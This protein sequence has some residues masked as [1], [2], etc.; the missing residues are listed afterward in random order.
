MQFLSIAK[1]SAGEVRAQLYVAADQ[2][3]ISE[4]VFGELLALV[5]QISRMLSGLMSY[6]RS[7]EVAGTKYKRQQL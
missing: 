4:Q 2:G 3:Y 6:L 1:G 5:T 7:S